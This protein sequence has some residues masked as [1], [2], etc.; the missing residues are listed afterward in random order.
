MAERELRIITLK[1]E[2]RLRRSRW[3]MQG[4]AVRKSAGVRRNGRKLPDTV[5]GQE[6][7]KMQKCEIR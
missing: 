1:N 3:G 7:G 6:G 2:M 5:R 4:L